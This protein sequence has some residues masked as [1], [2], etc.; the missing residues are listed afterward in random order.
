MAKETALALFQNTHRTFRF[1][2]LN[3]ADETQAVDVTGWD[4]SWMV[5]KRKS[6]SDAN[7]AIHKTTFSVT[8]AYNPDASM[9]TQ[10]VVLA[11]EDV[12]TDGLSAG[13]Y[14]HEL[15]RTNPGL[16]A[17]LSFGQ[18]TLRASLHKALAA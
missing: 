17:V 5:K 11:I 18:F 7:A 9:N 6:E 1:H 12:D 4:L 13:A 3:E 14:Y 15:K 16:E 2:V 8:G 10:R